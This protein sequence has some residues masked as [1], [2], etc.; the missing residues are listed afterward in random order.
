MPAILNKND[1]DTWLNCDTK[2]NIRIVLNYL[3][4]FSGPLSYHPVSNFVN[5]TKNNNLNCIQPLDESN[6]FKFIL[7]V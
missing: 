5:S 1:V 3:G 6:E 7:G 2:D 4:P